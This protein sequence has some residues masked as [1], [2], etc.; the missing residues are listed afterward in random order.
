M[1]QG[2]VLRLTLSARG[3]TLDNISDAYRRHILTS[4]VD[5]IS[6]RVKHS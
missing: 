4:K 5:P 1:A 2:R 3:P 6:E